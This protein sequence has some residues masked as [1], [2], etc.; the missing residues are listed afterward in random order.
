MSQKIISIAFLAV[1]IFLYALAF[2]IPHVKP[3]MVTCLF[4][5]SF[6]LSEKAC[7]KIEKEFGKNHYLL[8]A[9]LFVNIAITLILAVRLLLL[10][11]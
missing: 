5:F 6:L 10:T 3:S 7:K 1:S 9:S 11:V 2:L 4:F 8:N